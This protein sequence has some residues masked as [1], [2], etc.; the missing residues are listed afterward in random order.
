VTGPNGAATSWQVDTA[1]PDQLGVLS[2]VLARAFVSEPMMTWPLGDIPDR[3][4]AIET[5]FRR[6]D[7]ENIELGVVFCTGPEAGVAVWVYPEV[8]AR[9][10]ELERAARPD[11]YLHSDDGGARYERMWD[12]IEAQE[13]EE[14]AWYLDRVGVDPARRGEGIGRALIQFG[15]IRA[16]A[17][18]L[19]AYLE[20]ATERNVGLYRSLGFR[21]VTE[22]DVPGGGP[23]IWFLRWD[24]TSR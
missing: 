7:A 15:L 18:G 11:V 1:R 13:P 22:G 19:P 21:V 3:E 16:A 23:R 8:R 20:T 24:P 14:P 4:R 2:T 5:T 6:W 12:W 10:T 17:D 9:W